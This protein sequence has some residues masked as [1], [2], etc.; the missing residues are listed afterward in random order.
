MEG[1]KPLEGDFYYFYGDD[2]VGAVKQ[3]I[4]DKDQFVLHH[5][6]SITILG[7]PEGTKFTVKEV[8]PGDELACVSRIRYNRRDDCQRRDL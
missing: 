7:L 2:K 5:D 8:D 1:D 6:E 3:T 4:G